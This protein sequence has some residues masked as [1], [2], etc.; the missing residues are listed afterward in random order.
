M[1]IDDDVQQ[2]QGMTEFQDTGRLAKLSYGD[3]PPIKQ[4]THLRSLR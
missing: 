2:V 1:D 3:E 4:N